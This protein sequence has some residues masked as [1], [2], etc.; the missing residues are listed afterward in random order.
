MRGA[1]ILFAFS[2]PTN[3]ENPSLAEQFVAY[4]ISPD[5]RRVLRSQHLDVLDHVIGVGTGAP[6]LL[7]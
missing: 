6:A 7:R 3:A 1:P 5:G 4:M 2:I